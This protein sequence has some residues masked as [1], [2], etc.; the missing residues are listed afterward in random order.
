MDVAQDAADVVLL[1]P[2]LKVLHN[3]ILEGRRALATS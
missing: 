2:G 3:G 1:Q